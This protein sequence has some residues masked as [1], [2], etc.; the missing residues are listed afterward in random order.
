MMVNSILYLEFTA[1]FEYPAISTCHCEFSVK[2]KHITKNLP[3]A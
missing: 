1:A 2:L 3:L